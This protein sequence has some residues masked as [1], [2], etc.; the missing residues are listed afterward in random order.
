[1]A[2]FEYLHP[3]V[4]QFHARK[5][6]KRNVGSKTVWQLP[7]GGHPI[8]FFKR[9]SKRKINSLKT[10]TSK[11]RPISKNTSPF[12]SL[13][14]SVVWVWANLLPLTNSGFKRYQYPVCHSW[15]ATQHP[16]CRFQSPA[17]GPVRDGGAGVNANYLSHAMSSIISLCT[18]VP[19]SP[20]HKTSR[21]AR[22][23]G[24]WKAGK[25]WTWPFQESTHCVEN[26]PW[27]IIASSNDL[28][29][30]KRGAKEFSRKGVFHVICSLGENMAAKT[31]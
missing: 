18:N 4:F 12:E 15:M 10:T 9:K 7:K 27:D 30:W 26:C 29:I 14:D 21:S 5:R 1:M 19:I 13:K 8:F 6:R 17:R 22:A 28:K 2:I 23:R 11:W 24:D 25:K 31:L 3:D 20:A 16:L